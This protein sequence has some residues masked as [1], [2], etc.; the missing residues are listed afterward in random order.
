[1][2]NPRTD[3]VGSRRNNDGAEPDE[4]DEAGESERAAEQRR[5][6]LDPV[7]Q[8]RQRVGGERRLVD[9]N[10]EP[11]KTSQIE[12]ADMIFITGMLA[13]KKSL[14]EVVKRSK[15]LG[16]LIV[17]GGPYVTSTVEASIPNVSVSERKSKMGTLQRATRGAW[18]LSQKRWT[19]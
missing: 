8:R 1:M 18:L 16:K 6:L 9:L 7:E 12:W 19:G 5:A 15:Q 17:L 11:L 3:R 2:A 4:E 14:H 10:V 13:Q